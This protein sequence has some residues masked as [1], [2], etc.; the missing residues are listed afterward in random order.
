[1]EN[2]TFFILN[3]FWKKQWKDLKIYL[4]RAFVNA[5]VYAKAQKYK[6][7][8]GDVIEG[9]FFFLIAN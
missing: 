3:N 1:M 8:I 5:K 4:Q 9:R 2:D 7:N 6:L